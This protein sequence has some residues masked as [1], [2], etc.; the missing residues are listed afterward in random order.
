[1]SP[2]LNFRRSSSIKRAGST[3]HLSLEV[4][5]QQIS[6]YANDELLAMVPDTA[7]ARGDIQLFAWSQEESPIEILFDNLKVSALE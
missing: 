4:V 5:G 7:F 6:M 3:N 2:I 1:M